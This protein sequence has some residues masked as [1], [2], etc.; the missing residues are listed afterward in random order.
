MGFKE[1][2]TT[3]EI[4]D[5]AILV[6]KDTKEKDKIVLSNDAYAIGEMLDYLIQQL[7]FRLGSR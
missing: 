2:Y 1:Q 3:K 5:V 4:L 7:N 6:D